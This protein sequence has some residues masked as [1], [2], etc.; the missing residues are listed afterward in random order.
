MGQQ[1]FEIIGV[2]GDTRS[3]ARPASLPV[4]YFPI[5]TPLYGG[6]VPNFATLAVRSNHD[7]VKLALPIQ[8]IFAQL[9]PELAVADILTMDQLMSKI[10]LD[11]SFDI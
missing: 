6:E 11:A 2:V 9:D 7:V 1:S 3:R 4:M 8:R 5:Y 10:T